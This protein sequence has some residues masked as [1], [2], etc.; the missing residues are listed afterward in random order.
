MRGG[1]HTGDAV[2]VKADIVTRDHARG[3][4]V[5]SYSDT[6]HRIVRPGF[7]HK[8]LLSSTGGPQRRH[9]IGERDE[10]GIARRA[11]LDTLTAR[12]ADQLPVS[13]E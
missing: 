3:A 11:E 1:A 13:L 9:R 8:P 2:H 4:T 6:E 7:L 12:I 5:H 10:D